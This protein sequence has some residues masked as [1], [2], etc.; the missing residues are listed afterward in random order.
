MRAVTVEELQKI[1][2]GLAKQ[3]PGKIQPLLLKPPAGGGGSNGGIPTGGGAGGVGYPTGGGGWTVVAPA[4]SGSYGYGSSGSPPPSTP[5]PPSDGG[6]GGGDTTGAGAAETDTGFLDNAIHMSSGGFLQTIFS[7]ENSSA[8][9]VTHVTSGHV[10]VGYGVDM[11]DLEKSTLQDAL[12]AGYISQPLYNGLVNLLSATGAAADADLVS[13]LGATPVYNTNG[14]LVGYNLPASDA[15]GLTSLS[16]VVYGQIMESVSGSYVNATG[17]SRQADGITAPEHLDYLPAS[18]DAA[19]TDVSVRFGNGGMQSLDGGAFWNDFT[20]YNWT[21]AEQALL[22]ASSSA[23]GGDKTR[24]ANDA[25]LI[26]DA[27]NHGLEDGYPM[28]Q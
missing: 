8:T 5:D 10:T 22:N 1:A 15:A 2:G 27:I 7:H 11:H 21:G 26:Q 13:D 6:S 23:T 28:P 25:G 24:L 20:T 16:E 14:T 18:A 19:L 9:Y 12:D 3:L 17:N 4:P